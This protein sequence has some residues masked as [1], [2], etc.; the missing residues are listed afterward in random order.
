MWQWISRLLLGVWFAGMIGM[1]VW[2]EPG[3][4]AQGGGPH[5]TYLPIAHNAYDPM[6]HAHLGLIRMPR[7]YYTIRGDGSDWKP[8]IVE[9]VD[10]GPVA[11]SPDGE[12]FFYGRDD[13]YYGDQSVR[14]VQMESREEDVLLIGDDGTFGDVA[15]WSP[16]SRRVAFHLGTTVYVYDVMAEHLI[17]FPDH[18]TTN[19][20]WSANGQRIAFD[21]F[22]AEDNHLWMWT[23]GED[24]PRVVYAGNERVYYYWS[25]DSTQLLF[26]H[27][28]PPVWRRTLAGEPSTLFLQDYDIRGWVEGGT[29]LLLKRDDFLYMA[30]ADGSFP[31]LFSELSSGYESIE[32]TGQFILFNNG[33]GTYVQATQ[34]ATAVAFN[35][36][37]C[38]AGGPYWLGVTAYLACYSTNGNPYGFIGSTIWDVRTTPITAM[39]RL[40]ADLR[41]RKVPGNTPFLSAS[42][43]SIQYQQGYPVPYFAGS[44]L[45][46]LRTGERKQ[47]Q[48]PMSDIEIYAIVEWRYMP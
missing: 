35:T 10:D 5:T 27:Q 28:S 11:W 3:E 21:A 38:N 6:W 34:S 41:P 24:M 20:V 17:S 7:S 12:H 48:Y 32:G 45:I 14:V 40:P 22:P 31:V 47:I 26:N 15:Y 1:V 4:E 25:P 30:Q 9:G 42:H 8:F 43:Y 18:P 13:Q 23:W 36:S 46:N 33:S 44:V 39:Y 37:D 16:D 19:I 29:R 2:D